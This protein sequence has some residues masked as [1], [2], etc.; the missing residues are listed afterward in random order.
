[1]TRHSRQLL[2]DAHLETGVDN[3]DSEFDFHPDPGPIFQ[4][5]PEDE[6]FDPDE[7]D[8]AGDDSVDK[9]T[10]EIIHRY[11]QILSIIIH[12]YRSLLV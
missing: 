9:R 7:E 10:E 3:P 5:A 4:H 12:A 11:V 8:V 2:A 6:D 1:M